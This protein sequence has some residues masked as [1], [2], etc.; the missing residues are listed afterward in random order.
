MRTLVMPRNT[1]VRWAV[2]DGI[3]KLNVAS[4]FRLVREYLRYNLKGVSG[5]ITCPVLICD[6]EDEMFF[7]GQSRILFDNLSCPKE[8]V[9]F[10]GEEGAGEHCQAGAMLLAHQRIFDWL[11]D[12]M[13]SGAE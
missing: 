4:P 13:N 8:L 10:S 11:D 2:M 6:S 9:L 5:R 12:Q 7:H 3:W 1:T